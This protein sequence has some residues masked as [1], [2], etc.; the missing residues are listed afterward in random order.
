MDKYP[1]GN[2]DIQTPPIIFGGNVF[3]WT[4][5]EQESFRMLDDLLEAGFNTIDTADIYSRWVD[6][7]EGGV[8]EKIIGN[9]M[10]DRGVRE[11]VNIITKVGKDMG[12]GHVDL[13]EPYILDAVEDSLKRLQIE[14][15]DLYLSHTDDKNTPMEETLGAYQKLIEQGKVRNIGASNF[16]ADRLKKA[17]NISEKHDLPR[18]EVLQPEY[19]LY[20]RKKFENEMFPVCKE[21]GLGVI[22]YFSLGSGFLTGK[23]RSEDDMAGQERSDF[24]EKYFNERGYRILDALDDIAEKHEISQAGVALAWLINKPMVTAPIASATKEQHLEAFVE[25]VNV[26]LSDEDMQLLNEASRYKD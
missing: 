6:G 23:Y 17:L 24:V 14:Q 9:W 10:A 25:A 4:L 8:S 20:D 15:I 26:D 3:G 22:P 13:T 21:Q 5:D 16:S 2:T 12:Q 11:Q 18:Y 7:N 1:L 19:N